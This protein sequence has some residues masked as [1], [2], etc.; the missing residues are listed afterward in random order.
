MSIFQN[1]E[2]FGTIVREMMDVENVKRKD[3]KEENVK[4]KDGKEREDGKR[5]QH[6]DIR[7]GTL[8]IMSGRGNRLE[9]ACRKL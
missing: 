4:R 7:V 3:G 1:F 8:N 2:K 6:E 9:M 5:R